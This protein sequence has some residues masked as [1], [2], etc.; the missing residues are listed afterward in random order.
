M[1]RQYASV[2]SVMV[3]AAV[4]L[5][6]SVKIT[7]IGDCVEHTAPCTDKGPTSPVILPTRMCTQTMAGVVRYRTT[8]VTSWPCSRNQNTPGSTRVR[9]T[10]F[11][12]PVATTKFLVLP[13]ITQTKAMQ[14][15]PTK[16]ESVTVTLVVQVASSLTHYQCC[17]P[18]QL[19]SSLL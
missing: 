9:A 7:L 15:I 12:G 1:A 19:T 13:T 3:R 17:S 18:L 2:V 5:R 6:P 10:S 4:W 16:E 14:A 8:Q 11:L